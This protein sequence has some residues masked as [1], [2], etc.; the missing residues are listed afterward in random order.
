LGPTEQGSAN[1][2]PD[3]RIVATG[4]RDDAYVV[5]AQPGK[6]EAP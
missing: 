3:P 2:L 5:V 1:C 4:G 6:E